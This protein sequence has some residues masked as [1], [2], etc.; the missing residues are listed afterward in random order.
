M[1]FDAYTC[2]NRVFQCI[3]RL[4]ICTLWPSNAKWRHWSESTLV[5]RHQA[6]NWTIFDLSLV[7]FSDNYLRAIAHKPPIAKSSWKLLDQNS[8]NF[9]RGQWVKHAFTFGNQE[10][11]QWPKEWWQV[12]NFGCSMQYHNNGV[13]AW[14]M[15]HVGRSPL[16]W[17]H[18][19]HDGVSNH[20]PHHCLLNRLFECTSKKTSK[21]RV[22]GLCAGNSP[23]KWPVTRKMF[24]FDDVITHWHS[25]T[26]V[27][28][29]GS[30]PTAFTKKH[31]N[32]KFS[33]CY[34][35]FV[36]LF[37]TYLM[38]SNRQYC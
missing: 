31:G 3:C 21:L 34:P 1:Y 9:P 16:R 7:R 32:S 12:F 22:T 8:F 10:Q 33:S 14:L 5:W 13:M 36:A 18:D 37:I 26:Q 27:H 6:I 20:Q 2:E 17:R 25:H 28:C 4:R 38:S 19:G 35:E 29:V 11:W 24:P 30:F 23:H 15:K